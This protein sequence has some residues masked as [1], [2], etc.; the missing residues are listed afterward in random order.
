MAQAPIAITTDRSENENNREMAI[1]ASPTVTAQHP[2]Q[3]LL[4]ARRVFGYSLVGTNP[5][6]FV[7]V[8]ARRKHTATKFRFWSRLEMCGLTVRFPCVPPKTTSQSVR[9]AH[10]R[11][12]SGALPQQRSVSAKL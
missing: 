4:W 11:N 7:P 3:T 5:G 12:R 2:R 6:C 1:A 10:I 9:T 8:S